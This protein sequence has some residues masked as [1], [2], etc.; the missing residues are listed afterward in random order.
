[1]EQQPK[2]S[3]TWSDWFEVGSAQIKRT[4]TQLGLAKV[5]MITGHLFPCSSPFPSP[6]TTSNTLCILSE[7]AFHLEMN[8][9]SSRK[10][11]FRGSVGRGF[12]CL[13]PSNTPFE[14]SWDEQTSIGMVLFSGS[15]WQKQIAALTKGD[16]SHV[17]LELCLG[18]E[19]PLIEQLMFAFQHD[20]EQG[21]A[22]GVLYS[23][24]L[25]NALALHLLYHY[26]NA[27]LISTKTGERFSPAQKRLVDEY[28]EAHLSC[29]L[30]LTE[31]ASLLHISISHFK[32]L[33]RITYG[34]P[35]YRFVLHQRIE[36]AKQLMRHSPA[37]SLHDIAGLCGFANQSHFTRHFKTIAGVSPGRF[38]RE[39]NLAPSQYGG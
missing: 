21:A 27:R 7:G 24:S 28:I 5:S 1:M 10:G 15:K 30:T 36:R 29:E 9:D 34:L 32:R 26:S 37:K 20:I 19:D 33:F 11:R 6:G 25:A 22:F 4:T 8:C 16:P 38:R 2:C 35:P 39:Y 3:N 23:D 31:L 14:A 18:L 12:M 13:V 17:Y